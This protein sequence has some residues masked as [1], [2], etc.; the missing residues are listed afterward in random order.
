MSRER[1]LEIVVFGIA[2]FP[3]LRRCLPHRG[4]DSQRRS[5]TVF[6]GAKAGTERSAAGALLRLGANKRN[7]G[8]QAFNQW[9]KGRALGHRETLGLR[10]CYAPARVCS[11]TCAGAGRYPRSGA[12]D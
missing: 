8:G 1:Q 5:E 11:A 6:I 2:V 7:G 4:H 12:A 3:H 9:G 10:R